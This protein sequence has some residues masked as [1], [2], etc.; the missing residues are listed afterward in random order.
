MSQ[1]MY[2]A[3]PPESGVSGWI[4][5]TGWFW[6]GGLVVVLLVFF[7]MP[8]ILHSMGD[9][10]SKRARAL[11]QAGKDGR[12]NA[13]V[14]LRHFSWL[15]KMPGW[16]YKARNGRSLV[17]SRVLEGMRALE[18]KQIPG[19]QL[20][21][22]AIA[23]LLEYF[24]E[25]RPNHRSE[26][27][28]ALYG[29]GYL[30]ELLQT[31]A[32]WGKPS[33]RVHLLRARLFRGDWKILQKEIV[34]YKGGPLE[35]D[36]RN[37]LL[38]PT[39]IAC[40]QGDYRPALRALKARLSVPFSKQPK[41][42]YMFQKMRQL[43][44]LIME[45]ECA[46][47]AKATTLVLKAARR[48]HRFSGTGQL[49]GMLYQAK[50]Y[51]AEDELE[52]ALE[53]LQLKTLPE[54]TSATKSR[55]DLY[56]YGVVLKM[57]LLLKLEKTS[58][59]VT[60]A[61]NAKL[62]RSI[63]WKPRPFNH[64]TLTNLFHDRWFHPLKQWEEISAMLYKESR[65]ADGP[66]RLRYPL[67]LLLEDVRF[68]VAVLHGI[69]GL[70]SYA[71]KFNQLQ[72]QKLAGLYRS[73]FDMLGGKVVWTQADFAKLLPARLRNKQKASLNLKKTPAAELWLRVKDDALYTWARLM[74]AKLSKLQKEQLLQ[75]LSV[76]RKLGIGDLIFSMAL[77]LQYGQRLK[78]SRTNAWQE[79]WRRWHTFLY[80]QPNLILLR[81]QRL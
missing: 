41:L 74:N 44:H 59:L 32:R 22:D 17:L 53:V 10:A 55:I 1:K 63:R 70:P 52:S 79:I 43:E 14:A 35:V 57:W 66:S 64:R 30:N 23:F 7:G 29:S 19:G 48:L 28:L 2:Q 39:R 20:K 49:M 58:E 45:T 38:N 76:Q 78:L 21:A 40:L 24:G 51:I 36:Y 16:E 77:R 42:R 60:F 80:Q 37:D 75:R 81:N 27:E 47:R 61:R 50:L 18:R 12:G 46:W 62:S 72:D 73:F 15:G 4:K 11:Y 5:E 13:I 71:K 54:A 67:R 69:R 26:V 6:L 33:N 25:A 31:A 34:G 8:M 65:R 3:K 68:Q 9:S 56:D